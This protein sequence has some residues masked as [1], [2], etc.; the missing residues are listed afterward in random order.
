MVIKGSGWLKPIIELLMQNAKPFDKF[1]AFCAK[2]RNNVKIIWIQ[3]KKLKYHNCF[4]IL[5]YWDGKLLLDAYQKHW[6]VFHAS[7]TRKDLSQCI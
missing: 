1:E 7:K 3:I 5:K 2:N 4:Y 6:C